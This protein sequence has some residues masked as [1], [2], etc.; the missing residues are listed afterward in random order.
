MMPIKLINMDKLLILS[1][2]GLEI[3]AECHRHITQLFLYLNYFICS[4]IIH[5]RII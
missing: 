4:L 2:Y 1:V 5:N 3:E